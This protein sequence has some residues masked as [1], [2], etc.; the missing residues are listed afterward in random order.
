[1]LQPVKLKCVEILSKDLPSIGLNQNY[2]CPVCK[3]P[4]EEPQT[5]RWYYH[6]EEGGEKHPIHRDA[7]C[8]YHAKEEGKCPVCR[9]DVDLSTLVTIRERIFDKAKE[10]VTDL[11]TRSVKFFIPA[12]LLAS[13]AE[14]AGRTIFGTPATQV[15]QYVITAAVRIFADPALNLAYLIFTNNP[16]TTHISKVIPVAFTVFI[17]A[18]KYD[19]LYFLDTHGIWGALAGATAICGLFYSARLGEPLTNFVDR[20]VDRWIRFRTMRIRI[21][22]NTA[23]ADAT[24]ANAV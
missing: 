24:I 9:K 21:N 14:I 16:L 11:G 17:V 13:V 1:M 5:N 4:P 20:T 3:E 19:Y 18:L 8:M 23:R 10:M 6:P 22:N 7:V 12:F 2:E 15:S